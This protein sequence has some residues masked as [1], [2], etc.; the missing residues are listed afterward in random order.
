MQFKIA[1]IKRDFNIMLRAKE[2]CQEVL[3]SKEFVNNEKNS[4]LKN[5]LVNSTNIS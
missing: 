5:S 3:S 4:K 1:D 2:D